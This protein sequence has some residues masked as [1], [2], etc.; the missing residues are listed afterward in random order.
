MGAL[1]APVFTIILGF[2]H[3]EI[4]GKYIVLLPIPGLFIGS[5]IIGCKYVGFIYFVRGKYDP[6]QKELDVVESEDKE[7][8]KDTEHNDI[9]NTDHADI[10][11]YTDAEPTPL[12]SKE[13]RVAQLY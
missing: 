7:Q 10:E 9:V 1:T 12:I 13:A 11:D 5:N 8:Q 2:S 6:V 4:P 3:E